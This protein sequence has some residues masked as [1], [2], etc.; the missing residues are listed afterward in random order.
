VKIILESLHTVF[1]AAYSALLTALR[2]KIILKHF[3]ALMTEKLVPTCR[4]ILHSHYEHHK[5]SLAFGASDGEA[6]S[7]PYAP[8]GEKEE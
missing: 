1:C 2:S 4:K 3:L 7:K 5:K 8:C 6:L